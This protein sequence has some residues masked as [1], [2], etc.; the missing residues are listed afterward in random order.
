MAT[1][2]FLSAPLKSTN[3]VDLVKPLTSYID[4]V[5]NTS[6]NNRSDVAEA[7]Q[8]LNKL[9]SKACCQPLD[10]HQS[11]L[12]VLTRYYDQLVAIENKI[13]ISATQ[14]PVVF[15]WKDAFDKGSLFSSRASLSLS[16]GSFERA[17]V[18]FNIGSLMSQI[19][20]AQQFH[21]DDEIKVS[22]KLFQQSAG[23]FA[24]LR[25]VV[26]GMVQQ[27]PT[28]DLMPD[29]LAALSALMT[30]QAQEA[31]YIKGHKDK[32]KATSM[33]KISAQVA[34]FYSEAQKMMSKDIVRGLWDKDWSAIVSGKNLAYQALAQ[35]HQS[36]VCGEARQIGEQLSR[37]AESLKLFDTAQKYLPRDITG[38]WDIYPS[39]SKAHAAAK[40]DNDFIYHE[41]VS[42]FRTLPTLPKAVLAKP[43]PMQTPM[44]P[45]FRGTNAAQSP[46]NAPPRPPPPRPAAPSVESPIPPPRT[47]Q[48][49]Q[50]T[51]GAPPQYNPYQQQQQPQ[52]QQFQ[53][54]PGYYQQPMPYG[55][56][57]P[58]FQPQYQ[59][60]FA[61]PYPTF[62]GAFPSYQQQWP[63]QQQQGGFP[64]NPQFG[65]QN[66]QQGGGGGA[67]PF[68]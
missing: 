27:E 61:A 42:D 62:P 1:F 56:P 3:E 31:I 15:K 16:D 34:E 13:I 66:Q 33:V 6:D 26:L 58:M 21:T 36:E 44:T 30:A 10:K 23:V 52:M 67:N 41:K 65:Q 46:A 51:P 63:Q 35:Y 48:S 8:E 47:Q 22:A 54:H 2:G 20:A 59:P 39:V 50:A 11:A 18:L 24:R 60:T 4:N 38:I 45:S 32:M 57:Q 7:V 53:Q 5:Y 9:R 37:L 29:T 43:T 14:N 12:D 40:K 25:D 55:Q 17:A 68:Q 49:M 19:G 28:P 64:P